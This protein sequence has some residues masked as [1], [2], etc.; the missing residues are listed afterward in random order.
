MLLFIGLAPDS[1]D[2]LEVKHE[3]HVTYESASESSNRWH[4]SSEGWQA[5][6]IKAPAVIR[7]SAY[8]RCISYS[9]EGQAV[10]NEGLR[11]SPYW[12]RISTIGTQH[13][14]LSGSVFPLKGGNNGNHCFEPFSRRDWFLTGVELLGTGRMIEGNRLRRPFER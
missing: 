12:F 11:I 9:S 2:C 8:R 10:M 13:S 5:V 6:Q 3:A 14:Q 7:G 1:I 4:R